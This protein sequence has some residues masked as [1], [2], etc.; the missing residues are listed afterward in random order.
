MVDRTTMAKMASRSSMTRVPMARPAN[1]SSFIPKSSTFFMVIMVEDMASMT[2]RKRL[3]MGPQPRARPSRTPTPPMPAAWMPADKSPGPPT[4]ASLCR[5]NSSP[6][7]NMRKITP[8]SDQTSMPP[9]SWMVGRKST[10]GPARNPARMY[11]STEGRW[12]FLHSRVV[13]AAITRMMVRSMI[14]AGISCN[15]TASFN[16][17][18]GQGSPFSLWLLYGLWAPIAILPGEIF[19]PLP[20]SDPI[21]PLPEIAKRPEICYNKE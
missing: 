21:P 13:P 14:R 20:S 4:S 15:G 2:P 18:W 3:F 16:P 7:P 9:R 5:E 8:M 12:I 17:V 10:T 11:P 6:R 1:F 19:P